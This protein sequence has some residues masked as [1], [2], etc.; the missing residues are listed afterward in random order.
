MTCA[1]YFVC[2]LTQFYILFGPA[3]HLNGRHVVFGRVLAGMDIVRRVEAVGS[4]SG[5][6]TEPV[7]IADCGVLDSDAAVEKIMDSN[8]MLALDRDASI[9]TWHQSMV[10]TLLFAFSDVSGR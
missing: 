4:A 1:F 9:G 3:P 2:F 10:Q 8:K 6:P 7:V 5:S